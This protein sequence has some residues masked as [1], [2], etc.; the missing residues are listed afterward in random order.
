[1][2]SR[3]PATVLVLFACCL[4]KA[5]KIRVEH[6]NAL[7][8]HRNLYSSNFSVH[9]APFLCVYVCECARHNT[10]KAK[11]N[12]HPEKHT[13]NNKK[14]LRKIDT[15]C[16]SA[17]CQLPCHRGWFTHEVLACGSSL[18]ALPVHLTMAIR[19]VHYSPALGQAIRAALAASLLDSSTCTPACCLIPCPLTTLHLL[20]PWHLYVDRVCGWVGGWCECGCECKCVCQFANCHV[21]VF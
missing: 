17:N 16:V 9:E 5:P 10:L 18:V 1:M 15:Q 2:L 3:T 20:L 4:C 11:R 19:H 7:V 21:G 8:V 6:T 14:I 12:K 13:G